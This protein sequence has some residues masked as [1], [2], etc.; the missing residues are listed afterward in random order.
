MQ[1][2]PD[3]VTRD[4]G[5]ETTESQ[6]CPKPFPSQ[7]PRNCTW[8]NNA[9]D[10]SLTTYFDPSKPNLASDFGIDGLQP[11]IRDMQGSVFLLTSGQSRFYLCDIRSGDMFRLEDMTDVD[12]AITCII[13]DSGIL[14][15]TQIWNLAR[16]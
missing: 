11:I 5:G 10:L 8:S 7:L 15:K 2:L 14:R 13:R 3:G 1:N 9:S 6:P 16:A 12:Q 4:V